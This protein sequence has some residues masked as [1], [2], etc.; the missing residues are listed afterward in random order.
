MTS[1]YEPSADPGSPAPSA[2]AWARSTQ[3]RLSGAGDPD[4]G[5]AAGRSAG[6]GRAGWWLPRGRRGAALAR[7][8]RGRPADPVW[9]RPGLLG[10]LAATTVLYI[11]G[12]GASG[13]AN[14]FYAAAVQAGTKS[15]KAFLFGSFD[16]SN[17]IT[18]DK[19][20]GALWLM[21]LSG[22]IF[23]FSSWSMLIPEALEG[24]ATVGLVYLIV[25]RWFPAGAALAAGA[26]TA[27]TPVAV[28]MFRFNNP[29]A[30]MVM[31]ITLAAYA[32]VRVVDGGGRRWALVAGSAV[33]FAFLAKMLQAFLVVP[34]L[35]AVILLAAPGPVRRRLVLLFWSAISLVVS[36]GWWI[37]IVQLTPA[38]DRPYIG[39]S[40]DNSLWNL[41]FGYNGFGRLTGNETGSVGGGAA[42]TAGRWGPTGLTRLFGAEMGTQISWL[43]PAAL[44]LLGTGLVVT[45]R[46]PRV[47]R[48]R[49]ALVLW[50]GWLV[51]TGL[52]FI[53]GQGII[54]QYYTVALAPAIGGLIG[55]GGA[56]F[57][58][59]REKTVARGVLAVSVLTTAIWAAVLLHRTPHWLPVLAP[60]ILV[61]GVAGAAGIMA[62]PWIKGGLRGGAAALAVIACLLA[63]TAYTF[64]TVNTPHT[65]AIPTAGPAGSSTGAGPG[66]GPGG[67]PGRGPGGFP[68]RQ[69]GGNF[70][71]G[72]G[73]FPGGGQ[74]GFPGGGQGG[75]PGGPHGFPGAAGGLGTRGGNPAGGLL[76][77]S[78]P[79][80]ALKSLLEQGASKYEWVAAAV[81][82][83]QA[84]GYQLATGDAV[85]A[86]GG[87]NGTDPYPPLAQFEKLVAAGKVHYFIGGGAGGG[88][89][90]GP[91]GGQSGTSSAV[92][93]WVES[94]FTSQTV[95]GVTVYDLTSPTS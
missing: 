64:D 48:T 28:L 60:M 21:E 66:A 91:G 56:L 90:G 36:A 26:V 47:N 70:A 85:M 42:G 68:G 89:A 20:P 23:A 69:A 78:A 37:A 18:V 75:F 67:G 80:A 43:V 22:R 83:N 32:T 40:Q 53:L 82:A 17:F 12:L 39:G 9:V 72:Q 87:F 38:A 65:G 49:A 81:G 61:A 29:D 2:P 76:D 62:W 51:V 5:T 24:V 77:A 92:S 58:A 79:T 41:I 88:P 13:Y 84:A 52:A 46:L 63:P 71:G 74:G 31:L 93:S 11:W 27:L 6:S 3:H 55:T 95:G 30:L 45:R 44:V 7:F 73:G 33:G 10:L 86:I 16:P 35:G 50:G 54:H 19:S 1:L 94:H 25:R 14:S 57:W 59:N 15:W 8:W 34:A 4:T